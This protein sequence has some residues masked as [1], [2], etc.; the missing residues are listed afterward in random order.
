MFSN[1]GKAQMSN[2]KQRSQNIVQLFPGLALTIALNAIGIVILKR[3]IQSIQKNIQNSHNR[4]HGSDKIREDTHIL[5]HQYLSA[6]IQPK[7]FHK[8]IHRTKMK[9]IRNPS[10]R[11]KFTRNHINERIIIE[12]NKRD[13]TVILR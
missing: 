13:K 3:K 5:I 8:A 4:R 11:E 9:E 2:A 1:F 6:K 7:A 10:F 12:I